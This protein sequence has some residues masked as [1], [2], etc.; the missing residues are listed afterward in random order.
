MPNFNLS[1]QFWLFKTKFRQKR[2]I[3]VKNR[4]SEHHHWILHIRI[5]L[6]VNFYFK[7]RTLNFVQKWYLW[8]KTEKVNITKQILKSKCGNIWMHIQVHPAPVVN[9]VLHIWIS[10]STKLRLKYTIL[11][12]LSKFTQKEYFQSKIRKVNTSIVFYMLELVCVPNFTL[13]K[14]FWILG[15]KLPKGGISCQKEENWTALL[16]STYSN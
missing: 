7:Q 3:S 2:V 6:Y 14:Q 16:N 4:E 15:Q 11:I 1:T 13:N 12:F 5:S 10:L 9:W 8:S